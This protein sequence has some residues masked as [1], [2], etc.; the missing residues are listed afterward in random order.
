MF[1][2]G[3]CGTYTLPWLPQRRQVLFTDKNCLNRHLV[4]KW[5]KIFRECVVHSQ[6]CIS[7]RTFASWRLFQRV[8]CGFV[9]AEVFAYVASNVYL[10]HLASCYS[11]RSGA[12]RLGDVETVQGKTE[13]FCRCSALACGKR[14]REKAQIGPILVDGLKRYV[15]DALRLIG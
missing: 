4:S 6:A 13:R 14:E 1:V 8:R 10:S 5:E 2:F 12:M 9:T 3:I 11:W 15:E 7:T